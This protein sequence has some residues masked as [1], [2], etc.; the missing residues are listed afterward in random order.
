[1]IDRRESR[2]EVWKEGNSGEVKDVK[3]YK[4]RGRKKGARERGRPER[5]EGR[6]EER[7]A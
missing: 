2:Q 3:R 6:E 1:M 4:K 7:N 5:R